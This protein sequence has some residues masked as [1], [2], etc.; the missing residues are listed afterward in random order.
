MD[1][2]L[3]GADELWRDSHWA[4]FHLSDLF[5]KGFMR[6]SGFSLAVLDGALT[7]VLLST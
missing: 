1:D 7:V 4:T 6:F 3:Q 5:V 2:G